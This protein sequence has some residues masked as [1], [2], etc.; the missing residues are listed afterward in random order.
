MTKTYN[1]FYQFLSDYKKH[2]PNGHYFDPDTLK[3]FGERLSDMR[4]LKGTSIIKNCY[5]E[6]VEVYVISRYQRKY[7]GGAR[8]TQ[9]YFDIRTFDDIM[10][11]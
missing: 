2:N 1:N 5:G 7:P 4:I 11:Y 6:D 9:A 3:W 8:R 10:A